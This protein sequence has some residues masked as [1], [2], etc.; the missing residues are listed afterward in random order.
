VQK[1]K[2]LETEYQNKIL[3]RTAKEISGLQLGT[4]YPTLARTHTY[5]ETCMSLE[6]GH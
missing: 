6:V 1:Q 2:K 5:K 3:H 4:T